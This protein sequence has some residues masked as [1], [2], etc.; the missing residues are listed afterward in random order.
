VPAATV[1]EVLQRL[2]P[3]A[4]TKDAA[5]AALFRDVADLLLNRTTLRIAGHPHRFTELELYF[6]GHAHADPFTHGDPM[7]QQ[8][9]TWYFHRSGQRYRSGTYKG[10][11]LSFGSPEAFGGILVRG[12]ERLGAAPALIDGPCMVVDH[13]L[14]LT[15]SA[16]IEALV[17]R[18]DLAIDR[19]D[20]AKRRSHAVRAQGEVAIDRADSAK[21]RSHAVRAQGEVAIESTDR[22]SPLHV[23]LDAGSGRGLEVYATPRIGLTLKKGNTEAR[24]QF[25]ARPY[26]FLSEP[27]RIRKG[28]PHLVTALHRQGWSPAAIAA[29]TGSRASVIQGYVDAFEAGRRRPISELAGELSTAEVCALFGAC[30]AAG[31]SDAIRQLG[32]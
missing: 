32:A 7:Q 18:F 27:G 9:G 28:K 25:I 22:R 30:A 23:E 14:A 12:V 26:R 19:A 20:S 10:L 15:A 24:R 13:I 29:V 2:S 16:S 8:L 1:T 31:L 5:Y 6:T 4:A 21:R 11:D 3:S 17:S